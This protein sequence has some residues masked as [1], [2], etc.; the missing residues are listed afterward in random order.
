[1]E[2]LRSLAVSLLE[3]PCCVSKDEPSPPVAELIRRYAAGHSA[4]PVLRDQLSACLAYA[5]SHS[6]P[7]A[8]ATGPELDAS[9]YYRRAVAVLER[10]QVEWSKG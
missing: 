7:P 9:A 10:I 6:A 3:G 5:E 2:D 8:S 4:S 1:M